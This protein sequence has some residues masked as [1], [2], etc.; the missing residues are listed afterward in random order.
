MG[1]CLFFFFFRAVE[2]AIDG[3]FRDRIATVK[4]RKVVLPVTVR[5]GGGTFVAEWAIFHQ[6]NCS[7]PVKDFGLHGENLI[8]LAN[9]QVLA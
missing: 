5:T 7:M 8:K 9:L 4:R 3:H 6:G 1:F 2:S